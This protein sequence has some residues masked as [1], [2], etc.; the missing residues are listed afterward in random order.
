MLSIWRQ[1]TVARKKASRKN[2]NSKRKN[3]KVD[4]RSDQ[5]CEFLEKIASLSKT[6]NIDHYF[7]SG[8][9]SNREHIR[10]LGKF[11][12]EVVMGLKEDEFIPCATAEEFPDYV[13]QSEDYYPWALFLEESGNDDLMEIHHNR[14]GLY[15]HSDSAGK[16]NYTVI[17]NFKKI[18]VFDFNYELPEYSIDF[19]SLYDALRNES[20]DRNSEVLKNWRAFLGDFGPESSKE[21]KKQR[22]STIE[23]INPDDNRERLSYVKRF[24]H[25]PEFDKPIG[26]DGKGFQETFKT[27]KLPFL[28]TEEFNWDGTTKKFENKLIWGDNLSVMRSLPDESI[29]LIYL[30]PPFFSGRNYNCIFGDDDEVRTF[31]DIWDG[32]LPTYLAWLNARLWEMKRLLKSTGSLF[33]HLDW[34]ACHYVKCE[35]DK[36]FGYEN[37][38][39]EIVWQYKTGGSSKKHFSRKHD[40]LLSYAKGREWKFSPQKEKSYTKAKGRKAGVINYG[41]GTAEFFEDENGIYNL[42]YMR[43]VWDIPYINSQADERI[44]YPTQKPEALIERIIKATT[45]KNDLVADFFSGGGTTVAVAEKLGCRWIGCDVSRIAVSVARDRIQK[46]YSEKA[47]IDPVNKK[48]KYG[49]GVEYHGAYEKKTVRNLDE[50][51][52]VKFILQCYEAVPKKRGE[53]IQGFK[54]D[55][56]ICV[57]PAKEKISVDLVEDFHFELESKK[58]KSGII[59]A[60][61]W[62]KE[63]ERFL[64]ELKDGGHGPDIQLI[65]VKLV[66]IDSHEFKGDNIRFLNKPV[67]VIRYKES[68]NGKFVFDGTASQGRN[69]T[70]IHYY[71]WDFDYKRNRGFHP[72]TKPNFKDKDGDKNPLNDN[73]KIEYEFPS[74][75]TFNIALRII[76]KS[77]AEATHIEKI[78]VGQKKAA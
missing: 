36:I 27:K 25:M 51:T 17:T 53:S 4:L 3:A 24:G 60:W 5:F 18:G 12:L 52:Y 38:V 57:A 8:A 13:P 59:L 6:E 64:R 42:V 58:I 20:G 32:G 16:K 78:C 26:W 43:D 40:I 39:N 29:D 45:E 72:M 46:I 37:F 33:V 2:T 7:R 22:R 35:L 11:F 55:K 50:N 66:N 69:G 34:H 48:A 10:E 49:F 70:D 61:G 63:V 62:D 28:T 73:R 56:A 1:R 41:A 77:G 67:A 68:K 31:S 23:Y 47:G 54:N 74:E 75:G 19:V 14:A 76:D 65:Q 9:I 44:G 30:D 15:L 21:K 71:Q